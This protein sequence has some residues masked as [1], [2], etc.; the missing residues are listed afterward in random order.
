M[1][2]AVATGCLPAFLLAPLGLGASAPRALDGRV[3]PRLLA[4][5]VHPDDRATVGR[6]LEAGRACLDLLARDA[7]VS[8]LVKG[9]VGDRIVTL[10]ESVVEL[11]KELRTARRYVEQHSPDELSRQE[12]ELEIQLL[13]GDLSQRRT[14]K[15]QQRTLRERRDQVRQLMETLLTLGPRLE[16]A[17]RALEAQRSRLAGL[18]ADSHRAEAVVAELERHEQ[19]TRLALDAYVQTWRDLTHG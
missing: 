4:S 6:A 10:A 1:R 18:A 7:E 16:A 8:D 11:A 12:A 5:E 3:I 15:E 19:E 2:F 9:S 13:D 14:L 17:A